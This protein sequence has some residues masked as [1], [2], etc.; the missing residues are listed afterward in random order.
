MLHRFVEL[1]SKGETYEQLINNRDEE[2]L[3]EKCRNWE[4]TVVCDF[5]SR[6]RVLGR[7][8]QL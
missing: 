3:K 7:T 5:N 4:D 1:I 8:Y 6:N 2:V